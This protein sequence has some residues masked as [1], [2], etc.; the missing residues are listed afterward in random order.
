LPAPNR[1]IEFKEKHGLNEL[2]F[3]VREFKHDVFS[4]NG[5]ALEIVDCVTVSRQDYLSG[6]I[7]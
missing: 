7:A 1:R 4:A 6:A 2:I 3:S 5:L